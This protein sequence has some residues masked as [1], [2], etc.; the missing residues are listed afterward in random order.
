MQSPLMAICQWVL[1]I[2]ANI[3]SKW[4]CFY[5]GNMPFCVGKAVRHSEDGKRAAND[6]EVRYAGKLDQRRIPRSNH[7]FGWLWFYF[8]TIFSVFCM[9]LCRVFWWEIMT[10]LFQQSW[11][12]L[13]TPGWEAFQTSTPGR[14]RR[15]G[16]REGGGKP[17]IFLGETFQRRVCGLDW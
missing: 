9:Y 7:F 5:W 15:C 4:R 16:G 17:R 8:G 13:E 10:S 6:E 1:H 12:K 14:R 3:S 2:D 11:V